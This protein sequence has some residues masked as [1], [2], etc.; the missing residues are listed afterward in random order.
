MTDLRDFR[1][2]EPPL[3]RP[4]TAGALADRLIATT[5]DTLTELEALDRAGPGPSR[6]PCRPRGGRRC[7][8]RP[9][10]R[11]GTPG[12]VRGRAGGRRRPA[13]A[14]RDDPRRA[15]PARGR[16]LRL[17]PG[18][19]DG[20][21]R[22]GARCRPCGTARTRAGGGH[23]APDAGHAGG[24]QGHPTQL[25]G[26]R[27]PLPARCGPPAGRG[28]RRRPRRSSNGCGR[29]SDP[30]RGGSTTAWAR[31]CS[32]TS[33]PP[34][35]TCSPSR[36]APTSANRGAGAS[37]GSSPTWTIW[38]NRAARSCGAGRSARSGWR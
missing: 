12:G 28:R 3:A 27:R 9:V 8:Q 18:R 21:A 31:G 22:R 36:S 38:P 10:V 34:T 30:A 5:S 4:T 11:A 23:L 25:R 26:D 14:H 20:P 2:P 37:S 19:R 13:V 29:C 35:C 1:M 24:G 6:H 33:T 15:R 7:H 16:G 17:V 32:T